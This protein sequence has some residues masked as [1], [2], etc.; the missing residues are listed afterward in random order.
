MTSRLARL[1][2]LCLVLGLCLKAERALT[3]ALAPQA[4][5]ALSIEQPLLEAGW[6]PLG[7]GRLLADGSLSARGYLLG[8]CHLEVALLPP[9]H[10][11]AAILREAWGERAR[12]AHGGALNAAP[13]VEAGRLRKLA[14]HWAASLGLGTAPALFTLAVAL[15]GDCAGDLPLGLR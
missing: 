2:V 11:Y 7:A 15:E 5:A 12:F 6:L 13:P 4:M 9:G 1:L 10:E 8:S 14:H 3:R